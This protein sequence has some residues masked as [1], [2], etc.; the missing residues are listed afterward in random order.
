M[1]FVSLVRENERINGRGR[2]DI[3]RGQKILTE[4]GRKQERSKEK[5]MR[6][7]RRRKGL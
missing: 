6:G 4:E 7:K 3:S 1:I 5:Q 2:R